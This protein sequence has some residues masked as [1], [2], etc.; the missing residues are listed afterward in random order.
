MGVE[1][2]ARG[3]RAEKSAFEFPIRQ[4]CR[5]DDGLFDS[6]TLVDFTPGR[7]ELSRLYPK[8]EGQVAVLSCGLLSPAE[9][10]R[11]LEALFASALFTADRQSFL[12]YPDRALPGF[13]ERNRLDAQALAL[14]IVQQ[15]LAAGRTD[16]Q[17]PQSDGIVRFAPALCNRGDLEAAGADLADALP[18]LI[19]R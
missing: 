14:P 1:S 9:A 6:Y 17:Q 13:L 3:A 18:P 5:R 16:L 2:L 19:R 11:L 12:L 4:R 15:L 8:L 7:A 10:V